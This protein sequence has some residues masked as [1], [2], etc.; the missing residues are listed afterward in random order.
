MFCLQRLHI[1]NSAI[2]NCTSLATQGYVVV[3]KLQQVCKQSLGY[4]QHNL[5]HWNALIHTSAVEDTR[6]RKIRHL[7]YRAS[8]SRLRR[9]ALISLTRKRGCIAKATYFP[10]KS[11]ISNTFS[12]SGSVINYVCW[13]A[14]SLTF[15]N[16]LSSLW[17]NYRWRHSLSFS[18]S[19]FSG[20]PVASALPVCCAL[21]ILQ[22]HISVTATPATSHDVCSCVSEGAVPNNTVLL[23][24]FMAWCLVLPWSLRSFSRYGHVKYYI[25]IYG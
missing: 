18:P 19:L 4:D 7:G 24:W 25:W 5:L 8:F 16:E 10:E 1:S 23:T 11:G 2:H 6:F 14:P 17:P 12:R 20:G 15:W 13:A 9:W 21:R 22:G 3:W